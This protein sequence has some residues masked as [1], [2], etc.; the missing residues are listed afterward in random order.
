[1]V[2]ECDKVQPSLHVAP[3]VIA[4]ARFQ[5]RLSSSL[6][7]HPH[8]LQCRPMFSELCSGCRTCTLQSTACPACKFES[9]EGRPASRIVLP[10]LQ[11]RSGNEAGQHPRRCL[12]SI[13][14][15]RLAP[16]SSPS[17]DL[18]MHFA[19][20]RPPRDVRPQRVSHYEWYET[21]WHSS[22]LFEWEHFQYLR[23]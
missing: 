10:W 8:Q 21:R 16:L 22:H 9:D 11:Y 3:G 18:A 6:L 2:T 19:A 1:M 23:W 15:L 12:T 13:L 14:K 7:A 17:H 4:A 5:R 20:V